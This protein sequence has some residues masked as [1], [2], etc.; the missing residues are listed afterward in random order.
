MCQRI[1]DCF[2]AVEVEEK[3]SDREGAA[4]IIS[5]E[6]SPRAEFR[7]GRGRADGGM[8]RVWWTGGVLV[9]EGT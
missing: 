2:R 8:S 9:R 7:F 3:G 5:S 6:M 4:G 1:S